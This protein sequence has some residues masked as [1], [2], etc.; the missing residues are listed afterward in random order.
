MAARLN[1]RFGTRYT[2]CAVIGRAARLGFRNPVPKR[3]PN[4]SSA[5]A[6]YYRQVGIRRREERW[7]A[8]PALHVHY[9]RRMAEREK[10]REKVRSDGLQRARD[11]G[12][13]KTS[14]SYRKFLPR[15]GDLSKDELRAMLAAAVQNT[16]AMENQA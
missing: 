4:G 15:I 14:P 16:A 13:S 1:A 5:R 6:E 2:R 11:R 9:E 12:Q 3:K 8:N 7:A 10:Y